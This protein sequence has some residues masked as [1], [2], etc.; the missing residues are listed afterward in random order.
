M[1]VTACLTRRSTAG[2]CEDTSPAHQAPMPAPAPRPAPVA[3]ADEAGPLPAGP[4]APPAAA[5]AMG[6]DRL[7][8]MT[9]SGLTRRLAK[10]CAFRAGG[11]GWRLARA[12][13]GP[14]EGRSVVQSDRRMAGGR[15]TGTEAGR[16]PICGS[17]YMCCADLLPA[18]QG[19]ASGRSVCRLSGSRLEGGARTELLP[20]Q[21]SAESVSIV[22]TSSFHALQSS[23]L[24]PERA[25]IRTTYPV[26]LPVGRCG[27]VG[28]F[29]GCLCFAGLIR[30]H[31]G[32]LA[33]PRVTLRRAQPGVRQQR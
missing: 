24:Y 33:L 31:L 1:D 6:R 12:V 7:P 19:L 14:S 3:A 27:G 17:C 21:R 16:A 15:R 4:G 8:G 32:P 18:L 28:R 11:E 9:A 25:H 20:A 2:R 30:A 29:E 5:A 13:Q 26:K 10:I 22:A 23:S